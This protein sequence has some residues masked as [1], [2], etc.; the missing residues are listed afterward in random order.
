MC[1]RFSAV[2][3]VCLLALT[4]SPARAQSQHLTPNLE[5]RPLAENVWLHTSW[6][7]VAGFGRVR[8]HGLVVV[9]NSRALLVDTAWGDSL[10]APLLS[11]IA[12]ALGAT[13]ERAVVTH[14]HDD[15]LGGIALLHAAGVPTYALEATR[16]DAA[17][18]DWPIP[19]SVLHDADQLS[20]GT[21]TIETF[22]PGPGHTRDNIVVWL[23]EKKLLFGG[24]L[25][26]A[27][28]DQS[29]GYIRDANLE[30][31]P[32]SVQAL[33][34]RYP[35]AAVVIPSHGAPG[36]RSLLTHTQQLLEAHTKKQV[37]G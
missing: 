13:L 7:T 22:Y 11:W 23:P 32:T 14:A 27:A 35:E 19:D 10:T 6:R 5:V 18:Q 1:S 29:L 34:D 21:T 26:K 25:I 4:S 16:E 3:L 12:D 31:W 9:S 17:A 2:L 28:N 37:G 30:A 33:L 20:V 15:R 24:C 8:S 36:D